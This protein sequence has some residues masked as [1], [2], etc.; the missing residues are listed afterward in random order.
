MNLQASVAQNLGIPLSYVSEVTLS[1]GSVIASV[2]IA[3]PS[4]SALYNTTSLGNRLALVNFALPYGHN[5]NPIGTAVFTVQVRYITATNF[6]TMQPSYSQAAVH[7][8]VKIYGLGNVTSGSVTFSVAVGLQTSLWTQSITDG[9]AVQLYMIPGPPQAPQSTVTYTLSVSDADTLNCSFGDV[10]SV[11]FTLYYSGLNSNSITGNEIRMYCSS[12]TYLNAVLDN[13]GSPNLPTSGTAQLS[14]YFHGNSSFFNEIATYGTSQ[15]MFMQN[16]VANELITV[17]TADL[18]LN[19]SWVTVEFQSMVSSVDYTLSASVKISI[20]PGSTSPAETSSLCNYRGDLNS[21]PVTIY[22]DVLTVSMSAFSVSSDWTY[23]RIASTWWIV[24]LLTAALVTAALVLFMLIIVI[25]ARYMSPKSSTLSLLAS[26]LTFPGSVSQVVF[27]LYLRSFSHQPRDALTST[28]GGSHYLFDD[29]RPTASILLLAGCLCFGVTHILNFSV[30][31]F[32]ARHQ[33][34]QSSANTQQ[35]S[36]YTI[37]KQQKEQQHCTCIWLMFSCASVQ[38]LNMLRSRFSKSESLSAP[39]SNLTVRGIVLWS[40]ASILLLQIPFFI[41]AILAGSIMATGWEAPIVAVLVLTCLELTLSVS[42]VAQWRRWSFR[43]WLSQHCSRETNFSIFLICC[44]DKPAPKKKHST[45]AVVLHDFTEE[46]ASECKKLDEQMQQERHQRLILLQSQLESSNVPASTSETAIVR[47]MIEYHGFYLRARQKLVIDHLN[48][49]KAASKEFQRRVDQRREHN[50]AAGIM[51]DDEAVR[52]IILE[53]DRS[54]GIATKL[55]LLRT[56]AI[57]FQAN[58]AILSKLSDAASAST[59][60][61]EN[62]ITKLLQ[63]RHSCIDEKAA[64]EAE[65][66]SLSRTQRSQGLSIITNL[67]RQKS[68]FSAQD[69]AQLEADEAHLSSLR[70]A[71]LAARLSALQAK[72]DELRSQIIADATN[73]QPS[74]QQNEEIS[75]LI[76]ESEL[77][78]LGLQEEF[79]Q[80]H[81]IEREKLNSLVKARAS[82]NQEDGLPESDG[83]IQAFTT[84]SEQAIAL[85]SSQHTALTDAHKRQLHARKLVVTC[86]AALRALPNDSA[87]A[88]FA[89]SMFEYQQ[90]YETAVLQEQSAFQLVKI[91]QIAHVNDAMAAK[92]KRNSAAGVPLDDHSTRSIEEEGHRLMLVLQ[93]QHASQ[94]SIL[95]SELDC[96]REALLVQ[97]ALSLSP[98]TTH[99]ALISKLLTTQ[100]A[101]E[102]KLVAMQT[103]FEEQYAQVYDF[104]F[105]Y[106]NTMI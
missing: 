49:Q 78:E 21:F 12:S 17:L 59:S 88:K 27:L 29:T 96:R 81:R 58:A 16:L 5:S 54:A 64:I 41:L 42:F 47:N 100:A 48:A 40:L 99:G 37:W 36:A 65:H 30:A 28:C 83:L 52:S 85:L 105:V 33:V 63:L 69:F 80:A 55:V 106:M 6:P 73:M 66:E 79:T 9:N 43:R 20:Y 50:L 61:H 89:V 104:L 23:A 98:K 2:L 26:I 3:D 14:L 102:H 51:E 97:A 103:Q 11:S 75:K 74:T 86:L 93:Q 92:R 84:N 87:E 8:P 67:R 15:N 62:M 68:N 82:R 45:T 46:E 57:H 94:L 38:H 56:R 95:Q 71:E 90:Q 19:T 22:G 24:S 91:Q 25:A 35:P 7:I 77:K 31:C 53:W 13:L 72:E 1:C 60:G 34:S 76:S 18:N 70:S 4:T 10:S 32:F 39:L 101:A 44:V